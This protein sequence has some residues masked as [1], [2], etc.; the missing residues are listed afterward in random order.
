MTPIY[1]ALVEELG[2]PFDTIQ[3]VLAEA[4]ITLAK[5]LAENPAAFLQFPR[6]PMPELP[7][8]WRPIYDV[9]GPVLRD[10]DLTVTFQQDWAFNVDAA[11]LTS[12]TPLSWLD[13]WGGVNPLAT[14]IAAQ[15]PVPRDLL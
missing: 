1:T 6:I 11:R 10:E 7:S 5:W 14:R 8:R 15:V 4:A 3:W 9:V 12:V 2:D 13:R